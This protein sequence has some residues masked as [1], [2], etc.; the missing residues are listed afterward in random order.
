MANQIVE[1][2]RY[3]SLSTNQF[4]LANHNFQGWATSSGSTTVTY[5]NGAFIR[6]LGEAG[7]IIDLFAVWQKIQYTITYNLNGGTGATAP[8]TA[9]VDQGGSH[10]VSST[11]AYKAGEVSGY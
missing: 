10:T 2:G 5:R 11:T 6:D 4:S 7:E 3:T 9:T 1:C 8:A